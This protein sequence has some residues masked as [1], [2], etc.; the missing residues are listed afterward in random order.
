MTRVADGRTLGARPGWTNSRVSI[1]CR[2]NAGHIDGGGTTYPNAIPAG[3][4][5]LVSD[6][7][8]ITADDATTCEAYV[9]LAP[10]I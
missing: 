3:G 10:A 8:L 7:Y 1:A 5:Y 6:A 9:Q 2:D 4:Q